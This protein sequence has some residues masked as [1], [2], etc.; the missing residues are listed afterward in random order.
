[1][2]C[3]ICAEYTAPDDCDDCSNNN[4]LI[5]KDKKIIIQKIMEDYPQAKKF[6]KLFYEDPLKF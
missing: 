1:M 3:K 5:I 4:H 6:F 2:H